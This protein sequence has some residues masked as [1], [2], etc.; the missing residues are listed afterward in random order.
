M[1]AGPAAA[2]AAARSGS[3]TDPTTRRC[4]SCGCTRRTWTARSSRPQATGP[5][6]WKRRY[7]EINDWERYLADNGI[8][9]VK[10]FLNLSKEE[11][12]TRF[13]QRIDL[14]EKNWKFSASDVAGAPVLG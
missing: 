3:S 8:R 4:W 1:A 7:R 9:V 12:R 11:Q 5:D 2:G 10:L 6:V 13:L 14:P